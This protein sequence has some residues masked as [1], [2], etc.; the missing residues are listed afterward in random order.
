MVM[1]VISGRVLPPT[2][3]WRACWHMRVPPQLKQGCWLM[4]LPYQRRV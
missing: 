1:E 3:T 4:K 2:V